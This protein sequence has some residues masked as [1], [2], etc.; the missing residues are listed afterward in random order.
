M[1]ALRNR[2]AQLEARIEALNLR[3]RVIVTVALATLILFA[4]M[5][6]GVS[7]QWQAKNAHQQQTVQ[8]TEQAAQ[9]QVQLPALEQ[10][11]SDD[12][13]RLLRQRNEELTRELELESDVLQRRMDGL[14][15]PQH[16][17]D[18]LEQLLVQSPGLSVIGLDKMLTRTLVVRDGKLEP[19][20]PAGKIELEPGARL[21]Y[22]HALK[23][24][25]EGGYLDTLA[26]IKRLE[27]LEQTLLLNRLDFE[28]MRYPVSRA[29]LEV[30]TLSLVPGW[31]GG[32]K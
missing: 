21:I 7:P 4:V 27:A 12:P 1:N 11:L 8:L 2:I 3:E 14:V 29:I 10:R 20:D 5:Q 17:A 23:L 13:N 22:R 24:T 9:L 30:E 16:M 6:F 15:K 31:L 19:L 32:V 28:V 25:L 18:L 26:Y